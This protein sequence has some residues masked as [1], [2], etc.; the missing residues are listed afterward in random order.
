MRSFRKFSP[1]DYHV[2]KKLKEFRTS[3]GMSQDQLGQLCGVSF[4]QIQ[5]YEAVENKIS[6]AKLFEF[7]QILN[8]PINSFFDDL[9]PKGRHY[10]YKL[11]KEKKRKKDEIE[12]NKDLLPLIRA[13]NMIEDKQMKKKIVALMQEIAGPFYKKKNKHQYN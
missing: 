8:K 5:K 12:I 4:Q 1:A 11:T 3:L 13:F 2:A 9:D 7:A 10:N 6:A